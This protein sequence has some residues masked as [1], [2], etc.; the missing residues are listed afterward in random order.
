MLTTLA[1]LQET[2]NYE[3]QGIFK[4]C[5]VI[6]NITGKSQ[7][8]IKPTCR[9]KCNF[10]EKWAGGSSIIQKAL[11]IK[12]HLHSTMYMYTHLPNRHRKQDDFTEVFTPL[13][14]M[15]VST[16]PQNIR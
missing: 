12:K 2:K 1:T 8:E 16:C 10:R 7:T 13:M 4:L 11:Q 14:S 9:N 6:K 3:Y 5:T 15:K